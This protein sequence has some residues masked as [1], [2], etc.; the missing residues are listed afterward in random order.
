[1]GGDFD[2]ISSSG[3]ESSAVDVAQRDERGPGD[4]LSDALCRALRS[5]VVPL[6]DVTEGFRFYF[7]N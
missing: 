5:W 2:D 4:E 6:L 1:M 7:W 3:T